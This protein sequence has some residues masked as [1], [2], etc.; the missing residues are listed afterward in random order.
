MNDPGT[1]QSHTYTGSAF[2]NLDRG[3][4]FAAIGGVI[5]NGFEASQLGMTLTIVATVMYGL[6]RNRIANIDA[7]EYIDN[8]PEHMGI[9][10]RHFTL[11]CQWLAS[12]QLRDGLL[13][14]LVDPAIDG[15]PKAAHRY[16]CKMLFLTAWVRIKK[17][18]SS[19]LWLDR[20]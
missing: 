3:V 6:V 9:N 8:P 1:E 4:L 2:E 14:D 15:T 19:L 16:L 13:G 5:F 10:A 17:K 7:F 12:R 11:W 20:T 18:I